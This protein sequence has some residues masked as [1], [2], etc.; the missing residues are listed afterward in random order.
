MLLKGFFTVVVISAA[1]S[2][3]ACTYDPSMPSDD[4]R[5]VFLGSCGFYETG[6]RLEGNVLYLP[7]GGSHAIEDTSDQEAQA[8]L[9]DAYGLVEIEDGIY[10]RTKNVVPGT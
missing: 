1:N 9:R 8:L 10:V 3:L 4:G 7:R 2:G 6:Y 5:T